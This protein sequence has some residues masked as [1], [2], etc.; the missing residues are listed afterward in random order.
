[1]LESSVLV[2]PLVARPQCEEIKIRLRDII[3]ISVAQVFSVQLDEL[4]SA[5]RCGAPIALARQ[6][7]MYLARVVGRMRFAEAGKA[8]GRDSSTVRH[9]CMVVEDRRDH[10]QFNRTLDL[11]EGIVDRLRRIML[12]RAP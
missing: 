9:A 2:Q 12:P 8:F 6:V 1:M 10:P 7:A 4:R 3:E 5:S 11:L